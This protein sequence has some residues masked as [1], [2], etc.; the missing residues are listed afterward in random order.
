MVRGTRG[1]KT[2]IRTVPLDQAAA[3]DAN[4]LDAAVL[5]VD[6]E[7]TPRLQPRGLGWRGAR[8]PR[9]VSGSF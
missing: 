7:L 6:R 4:L 2:A 8:R 3:M 1:D 5:A 9:H